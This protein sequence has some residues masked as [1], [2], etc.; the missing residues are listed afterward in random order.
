MSEATITF[1]R[2]D[3]SEL[4]PERLDAFFARLDADT[5]TSLERNLDDRD[6]FQDRL[7]R[8]Y[9][10]GLDAMDLFRFFALEAVDW[11]Q[12]EVHEAQDN[13]DER[14][15][16]D[17]YYAVVRGLTA[18]AL[19]AY[20]EVVWLLRGGFP[21]GA[22]TRVRFLHE[23]FVTAAVLAEHGS[24]EGNH[25]ELVE[26]YLEH[27]DVFTR[28]SADDLMATGALDSAEYFDQDVLDG[29]ARLRSDLLARYGKPFGGMWGWA[30]PLFPG[31]SHI[32]MKMM[33]KLVLPEAHY[34]YGMT[35]AHVHAG[36]EGWHETVVIREHETSL[37]SGP[38]N[39]GLA[40][41][42]VLA[43]GFLLE[44]AQVV[45]PSRIERDGAAKN[46]GAYFQAALARTSRSINDRMWRGEEVI[47]Q[48]E[49]DF[50]K[51]ARQGV[52]KVRPRSPRIRG[53]GLWM[54][55]R[56]E[57]RLRRSL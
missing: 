23:L 5:R 37:T 30:A 24:P 50:Q 26:R 34:F 31:E 49:L 10:R 22:L 36:S 47:K 42:A 57:R 41:P 29:L 9:G 44:I 43:T 39:L 20:A 16:F 8:D 17:Q 4:D 15:D 7:Y 1:G 51:R 28:A 6:G 53:L 48:T 32:T 45:V 52:T 54:V 38:T 2:L 18:R 3:D 40:L 33:G 14:E 21:N 55:H 56:I 19:T 35:S 12:D 25:P 46:T 27:R 11:A 13:N